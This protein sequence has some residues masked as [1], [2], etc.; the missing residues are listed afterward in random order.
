M[1]AELISVETIARLDSKLQLEDKEHMRARGVPSPGRADSL[2][3]SFAHPVM[4]KDRGAGP[5]RRNYSQVEY[6]PLAG[7]GA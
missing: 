5:L 3:L 2:A 4:K 6:D 1:H 7:I